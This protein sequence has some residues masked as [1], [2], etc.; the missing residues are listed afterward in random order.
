M[1]AFGDGQR[2]WHADRSRRGESRPRNRIIEALAKHLHASVEALDAA[3]GAAITVSGVSSA[4]IDAT[5]A[6]A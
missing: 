4:A 2:R 3:P 5:S 1:D 6:A